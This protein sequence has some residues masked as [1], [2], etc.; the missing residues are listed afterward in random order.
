MYQALYNR[1]CYQKL[2]SIT[3]RQFIFFPPIF[4][5]IQ[6]DI[7]SFCSSLLF[8]IYCSYIFTLLICYC[9]DVSFEILFVLLVIYYFICIIIIFFFVFINFILLFIFLLWAFDTYINTYISFVF[10]FVVLSKFIKFILF[11]IIIY[12][13]FSRIILL[14]NDMFYY[15]FY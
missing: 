7:V 15:F 6:S 11:E 4:V 14:N 13:I 5:F 2:L 10:Q 1:S 8:I 9:V 12:Y 3:N